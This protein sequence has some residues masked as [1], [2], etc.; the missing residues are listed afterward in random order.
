M[1]LPRIGVTLGDPSGVGPEVVLKALY[2]PERLPAAEYILFASRRGL[3]G[4]QKNL[5]L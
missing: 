2:R 4:G 1:T 5:R 3:G